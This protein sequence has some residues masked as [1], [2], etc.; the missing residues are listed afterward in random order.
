MRFVEATGAAWTAEQLRAAEAELEAQKREWEAN[1]LAAM[2]KEEELLKQETEAEELL[3]Y[4]R[5]DSSKQVNSKKD[6][7]TSYKRPLVRV[8]RSN[9]S[10]KLNRSISS[11]S[12]SGSNS[13][14]R[15]RLVRGTRQNSLNSSAPAGV[16]AARSSK[17]AGTGTGT[18]GVSGSTRRR[19]S[20]SKKPL[21]DTTRL[22]RRQTRLHSLGVV[23][24]STPPTRKT[25]RTA[26]AAAQSAT[27]VDEVTGAV[28]EE[29]PKRQSANIAMSKMLRTPIKSIATTTTT[30][31]S[32]TAKTTPPKRG[33]RDSVSVSATRS[34]LL[35]RRA[36][37]AAPL[38]IKAKE[39][40]SEPDEDE[41]EAEEEEDEDEQVDAAEESEEEAA[42]ITVDED[43]G[44]EE[45]EEE[46]TAASTLEEDTTTPTESQANEDDDEEEVEEEEEQG[47]EVAAADTDD[48]ADAK[49][50]SS[51]A[52]A[53][54][55]EDNGGE[56]AESASLDGWNAHDQVQDTTM[57][58]ST[59]Y[60]VSEESDTDEHKEE[61][62]EQAQQSDK[63]EEAEPVGH[64]PRTRS[65]GSVKINLWTLDMS[66]VL[67][68][69]GRSAGG[70]SAK[71]VAPKE[72]QSEPRPKAVR[73]TVAK[74]DVLNKSTGKV[75]P[76]LG[77]ITKSP[78]VLL[79][80]TPCNNS[81]TT[82]S[83]PTTGATLSSSGST[84]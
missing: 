43:D 62:K 74:K 3:T 11:S 28:S 57:T 77:W 84:R 33:R 1:R 76:L 36:T 66:P 50:A 58:S 30:S 14:S 41:A 5:K 83:T 9:S 53:G 31:S 7:S 79:R 23:I 60:N 40:E 81:N 10:Q 2:H 34:K 82:P 17:G 63:S 24:V 13:N 44:E 68:N 70:R 37:I 19:S 35:A 18:T 46:E 38:A 49:S 59:Y 71:K 22:V 80:S 64:T 55:G 21:P 29:R 42:E 45:Q 20:I 75:N 4:S 54:E 72:T 12:H 69:L 39:E 26:L 73:R 51:Y 32:A 65:R 8:M 15:K 47:V 27:G 16:E 52:T 6:S 67:N 56:E 78:R 48:N 25:T 61:A